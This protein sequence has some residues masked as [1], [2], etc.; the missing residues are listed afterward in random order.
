MRAS[1][2]PEGQADG[3]RDARPVGGLFLKLSSAGAGERVVFRAALRGSFAPVGLEPSRLL[4]SVER[5]EERAW[6]HFEG[7]LGDL[8]DPS[9]NPHAMERAKGER[10]EDEK[11]ERALEE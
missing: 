8:L 9:G 10:L 2:V 1:C 4:H 3:D 6:S 7:A 11:V 5:R